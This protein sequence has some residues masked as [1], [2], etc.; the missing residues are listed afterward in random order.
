MTH[1]IQR[2]YRITH[3]PATDWAGIFFS[4]DL[5]A[6]RAFMIL[7]EGRT[8]R[9]RSLALSLEQVAIVIP[10]SRCALVDLLNAGPQALVA[11]RHTLETVKR[12]L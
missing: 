11:A 7:T 6:K 5:E 3:D 12:H 1:S 9:D 2:V 8:R 4:T 10:T